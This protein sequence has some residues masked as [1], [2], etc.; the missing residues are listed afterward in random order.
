[1]EEN[2]EEREKTV[3]SEWD[4]ND[5]EQIMQ[6]LNGTIWQHCNL[7]DYADYAVTVD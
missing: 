4:R 7:N 5:I 3:E 2:K 6:Y 1:M